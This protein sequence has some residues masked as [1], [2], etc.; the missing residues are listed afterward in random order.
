[1][2][3][4]MVPVGSNLAGFSFQDPVDGGGVNLEK[5]DNKYADLQDCFFYHLNLEN[6]LTRF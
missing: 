3:R 5:A 6:V 4:R 1:M 2:C